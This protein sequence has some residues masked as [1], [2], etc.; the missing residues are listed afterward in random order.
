MCQA[1]S[2]ISKPGILPRRRR[3]RRLRGGDKGGEVFGRA[4]YDGTQVQNCCKK[5]TK[6]NTLTASILA[7]RM[8]ERVYL[9]YAYVSKFERE[10]QEGSME[11]G[12]GLSGKEKKEEW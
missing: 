2:A 1:G 8:D 6:Q 5:G 10:T 7:V 3:D 4:S 12:R 9:N 11:K